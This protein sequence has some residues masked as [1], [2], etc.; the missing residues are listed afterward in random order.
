[1]IRHSTYSITTVRL[2]TTRFRT[3]THQVLHDIDQVQHESII[4]FLTLMV[5]DFASL[6]LR[7]DALWPAEYSSVFTTGMMFGEQTKSGIVGLLRVRKLPALL[8]LLILK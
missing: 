6:K 4:I 5:Y 8:I 1:M 3:T 7:G 2:N